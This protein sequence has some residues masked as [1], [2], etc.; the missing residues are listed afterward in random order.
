MER[1]WYAE[2]NTV[3]EKHPAGGWLRIALID[4]GD[5]VYIKNAKLIAAAPET[6]QQRDE[7]L[8]A[9]KR[10]LNA[11]DIPLITKHNDPGLTRLRSIQKAEQA[12]KNATNP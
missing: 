7:L 10:M 5:S 2:G 4:G 9:L 6:K 1:K 3:R 8:E 11:F 12:I